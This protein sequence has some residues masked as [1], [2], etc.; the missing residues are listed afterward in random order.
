MLER[1]PLTRGLWVTIGTIFMAVGAIGVFV[2]LLPTAPFLLLAAACYMRGSERLH[3]WLLGHR[4]LG[5]YVRAYE[6][7]EGVSRRNKVLSLLMLWGAMALTLG[8]F[9]QDWLVRGVVIAI[10]L[11]VSAH[12]L[13]LRG[14]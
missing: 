9:I 5:V 10:G 6:L 3:R 2:P 12:I 1:G 13:T 4:V 14:K 8:F 7:G 11:V